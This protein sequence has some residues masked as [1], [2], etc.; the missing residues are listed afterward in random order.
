MDT[1]IKISELGNLD[2]QSVV[3]SGKRAVESVL[4]KHGDKTISEIK[5]EQAA[6]RASSEKLFDKYVFFSNVRELLKESP[7]K[8]G[9]IEKKAD[10][11]PGYT[12]RLEKPDNSTDPSVEYVVAAAELLEVSVDLLINCKLAELSASE[13]YTLS[14]LDKLKMDTLDSKLDWDA[15]Y[16]TD[17]CNVGVDRDGDAEHPLFVYETFY[18]EG[19]TEY[20]D[21]ITEVVFKSHEYG[22]NTS[23][24]D[25]C[26]KLRLKNGA[27]LYVMS[28]IKDVY[29][30]RDEAKLSGTEIWMVLPNQHGW[31]CDKR[32]LCS[33]F[34]KGEVGAAV[35]RLYTT[36]RTYMMHPKMKSDVVSI[37]DAFMKDDLEDDKK[38]RRMTPEEI[39]EILYSDDIP[40]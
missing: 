29:Y 9:Q 3:E 30:T 1:N 28:I 20:P 13:R 21:Q 36:L 32:F 39:D 40:F 12:S 27:M 31:L 33:S 15:E 2:T 11:K 17:L 5:K 19:E 37:I 25:D 35:N 18:R 4:Q 34:D 6:R 16:K 26:Y 8:V 14:F 10:L 23:I 7:V 38:P 22:C 24:R